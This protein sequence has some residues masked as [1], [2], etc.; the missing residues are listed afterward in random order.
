[1]LVRE[2]PWKMRCGGFVI[3]E[4]ERERENLGGRYGEN[5]LQFPCADMSARSKEPLV[6]LEIIL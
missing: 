3:R 5:D 1:M 4:R 6:A 2:F